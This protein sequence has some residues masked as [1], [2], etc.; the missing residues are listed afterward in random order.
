MEQ[1][2]IYPL[3]KEAEAKPMQFPNGSAKPANMLFP[4]DGTAFDI[5]N[6]YIQH[7]YV[8]PADFELR[9]LLATLGIVKGQPFAPDAHLRALLDKGAK[10]A[11]RLDHTL[12][13]KPFDMPNA[14]FFPN[15]HWCNPFPGNPSFT[16]PTFTYVDARAGYFALAY[17]TS[18]GMAVT[19]VD[20]GAKYP[21]TFVDKDGEFLNGAKSYKLNLPKDIPAH[22]FWSVTVYDPITA[23]GLD[24]GQ[25]FPSLNQMDKPAANT[26]GSTDIYFGPDSPGDGRSWVRT[27]PGQGFFVILRIYGPT[28]A[29]F[30]KTWVP[31]DLEKLN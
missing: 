25:P 13:Y 5:I 3:G 8:D 22:L 21:S 7:E 4:G 16:G 27:V 1:T 28:Q 18:P 30:D 31:G 15:R 23:S 11:Y 20:V 14:V 2:R 12:T 26:D 10:T 6:R 24:N 17:A 19:M 9:G 29:F